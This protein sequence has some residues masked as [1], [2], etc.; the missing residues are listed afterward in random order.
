MYKALTKIKLKQVVSDVLDSNKVAESNPDNVP[1]SSSAALSK[2]KCCEDKK[3]HE[4]C[5]GCEEESSKKFE[6]AEDF[7]KNLMENLDVIKKA[8]HMHKAKIDQGMS[9]SGKQ[10]ARQERNENFKPHKKEKFV[11]GAGREF[12]YKEKQQTQ[13]RLKSKLESKVK[14]PKKED[15][16]YP[17]ASSEDKPFHGYNKEKHSSKGGLSAKARE[18]YNRENNSNLQ[19]PVS[20][21]EAKKSPKKASRRKSFCARM[22]GVKGP[23]SKKGKLTPKGA[24]L[25]RWDC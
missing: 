14:Y 13:E 22:S 17:M 19:A 3:R 11:E 20:S 8:Y 21:K 6:K 12:P 25:K 15:L 24:A 10:Q 23:T 7:V 9:V 5:K 4:H 16:E 2:N 1:A 18:K